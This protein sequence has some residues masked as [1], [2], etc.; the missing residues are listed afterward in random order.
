MTG[1]APG[2]AFAPPPNAGLCARCAWARVVR[3]GRGSV[4]LLCRRARTDERLRK[5]PPLP[6]LA[7]HAF[8]P[9]EGEG[10]ET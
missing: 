2:E 6:V 7:C 8:E 5:Y 9:L 1:G 10:C 4:F 3:S